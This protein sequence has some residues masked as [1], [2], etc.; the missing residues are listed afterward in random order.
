MSRKNKAPNRPQPKADSKKLE[1]II[2]DKALLEKAEHERVLS[3]DLGLQPAPEGF[4]KM[5]FKEDKFYT[6]L[7]NPI[8]RKGQIYDIPNNMVERWIKRGGTIIDCQ[9]TLEKVEDDERKELE[10]KQA[11]EAEQK[12]TEDQEES[13]FVDPNI[14]AGAEDDDEGYF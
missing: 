12:K 10:A 2:H 7:N 14:V 1:T 5:R 9:E 6:D 11:L 3:P 13:K 8:Y 4:V